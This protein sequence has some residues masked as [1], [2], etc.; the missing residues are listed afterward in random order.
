MSI[1]V[2]YGSISVTKVVTYGEAEAMPVE[3]MPMTTE[4]TAPSGVVVSTFGD[5]VS[6]IWDTTSIENAEQIKVVLYN[7]GVTAFAQPLITINPA[8]DP[9]S[10]T[11]NGVPD[12]TYNV[13]VASFRTG[14]PHKLSD[15]KEV[16]VN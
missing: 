9:G 7:S 1:T 8:N 11:F 5:S 6:V 16:T 2:V 13:V 3:P 12:G 14:E 15:L 4:L 10:A